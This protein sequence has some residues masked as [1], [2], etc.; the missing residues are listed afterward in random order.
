MSFVLFSITL[1]VFL[2]RIAPKSREFSVYTSF[3]TEDYVIHFKSVICIFFS[4]LQS[5]LRFS[6]FH[7][8][9]HFLIIPLRLKLHFP[10]L[11]LLGFHFLWVEISLNH[12]VMLNF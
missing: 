9:S 11:V 7:D 1:H 2:N 6:F 8:T 3:I 12:R 5:D 4:R 10:I